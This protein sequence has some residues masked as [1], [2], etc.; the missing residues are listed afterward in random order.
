MA[1]DNAAAEF[2][3]TLNNNTHGNDEG[4]AGEIDIFHYGETPSIPD[5]AGNFAAAE[6][7]N[8]KLFAPTDL[9]NNNS[10][11]QHTILSLF[12]WRRYRSIR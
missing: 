1:G 5:I 12:I 7:S 4:G 11:K 6:F 9:T 2:Q 8:P 3:L 10:W